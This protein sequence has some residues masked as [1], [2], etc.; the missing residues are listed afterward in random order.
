MKITR[1]QLRRIIK[2]AIEQTPVPGQVHEPGQ[3]FDYNDAEYANEMAQ[4]EY[5]RGFKDGSVRAPFPRDASD[6]YA[7][8]YEDGIADYG[9][10]HPLREAWQNWG[11]GPD[12]YTI[13]RE[14][15]LGGVPPQDD[16][17]DYM[18][19]YN[20]VLMDLGEPIVEPPAPGSGKPLDPAMLKHAHVGGRLRERSLNE[21]MLKIMDNPYEDLSVYNRIA[22]YALTNDIQ[23]AM[24][25][26]EVNTDE[27]YW[28]IDEMRPWVK[29]V[30]DDSDDWFADDAVVPDGWNAD[31]VYNFMGDLENAWHKDQEQKDAAAIAADPDKDWLKFMGN[32]W[33]STV[34]PDDLETLG[35]KEYKKYIRLSPPASM[36][37]AVGE[38]HIANQE[39]E[40]YAPGTREEFVEFLTKRAGKTLKKR[41]IYRS[42]PPL[43]D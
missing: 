13:G 7:A 20:E 32:E 14:D 3:T 28:E 2:E 27:L 37:H 41:K 21:E 26:P 42:P 15:A 33:T 8:G 35:W 4:A 24:A 31:K 17:P 22:N 39:I 9:H 11:E 19:G 43:Y 23:G 5:G 40:D 34:T 18:M 29:R 25:D 12:M 38:I 6:D 36:S 10:T 1:R 30:G 16:E